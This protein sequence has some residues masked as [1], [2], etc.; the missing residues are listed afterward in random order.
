[1]II[2]DNRSAVIENIRK[3]AE[4]GDFYAKVELSDPNLTADEENAITDRYL[5]DRYGA[6]YKAKRG[7]ARLI[8]RVATSIINRDT[9]IV[10]K[11]DQDLLA[12]GVIVTSNHFSPLENTAVRYFLRENGVKRLNIVSQVSNF[13]MGGMI[14]FLMNYSDTIPLSQSARYMA[15]ELVG[16]LREKIERGEAVLIYPEQEMWFNY[17]KPRPPKEGAYHFA[18][19]IGCPIVSLYV[20]QIDG[21]ERDTDEF[22]KVR[23]RVH[24]LGVIYPEKDRSVRENRI[25]MCRKDAEL[26]RAAY[27]RI[28]GKEL[29]YDFESCDIAGWINE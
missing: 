2:G 20:E 29:S 16:V 21:D 1:M 15:R 19:K 18:A 7:I 11:V 5:T 26:K 10:G 25:E 14:G 9:E 12:S 28:Y 17:R 3:S 27:E 24:V 8:T 23:Y 6:S 22:M 4:T 13:A